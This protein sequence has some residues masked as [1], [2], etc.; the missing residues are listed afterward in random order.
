MDLQE[1]LIECGR[2]CKV[3]GCNQ[4]RLPEPCTSYGSCRL[5]IWSEEDDDCFICGSPVIKLLDYC[6]YHEK[7]GHNGGNSDG[8]HSE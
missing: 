2:I 5:P 6:Y 4:H 1:M 8:N 3:S 7:F